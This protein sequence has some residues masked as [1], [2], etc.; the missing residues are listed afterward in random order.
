MQEVS[1]RITA[2]KMNPTDGNRQLAIESL[3]VYQAAAEAGKFKPS[4]T[5]VPSGTF[6]RPYK[7]N[8]IVGKGQ[9]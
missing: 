2:F 3:S 1:D 7:A 8:T 4:S 5:Y 6:V 9:E